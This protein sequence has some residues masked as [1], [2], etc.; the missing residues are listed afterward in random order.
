MLQLT[1]A[2]VSTVYS[3]GSSVKSASKDRKRVADPLLGLQ[4]VLGEVEVLVGDDEA[5]TMPQL[6]TLAQLLNSPE[7]LIRCKEL[8]TILKAKLEP[9]HGRSHIKEALGWP[10]QENDVRKSVEYL[11][12]FQQLLQAAMDIDQ[13]CVSLH[14]LN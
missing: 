4:R 3:Y 2:T 12:K 14:L 11:E 10:L 7:G 13:T 9:K 1:A 5:K 8:L 6:P